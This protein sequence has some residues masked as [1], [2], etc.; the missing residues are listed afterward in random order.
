MKYMKWED[1]EP[2][3][4]VIL[5]K[6]AIKLYPDWSVNKLGI[7]VIESL[8]IRAN[9]RIDIWFINDNSKINSISLNKDGYYSNGKNIFIFELVSLKED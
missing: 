9:G 4:K 5:T 8:K 3:D 6:E 7:L 1:L 2:G